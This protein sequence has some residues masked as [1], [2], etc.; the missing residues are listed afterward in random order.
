MINIFEGKE[1]VTLQKEND[2][3]GKSKRNSSN[4][5]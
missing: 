3:Y 1:S 2:I 5:Y 4:Q